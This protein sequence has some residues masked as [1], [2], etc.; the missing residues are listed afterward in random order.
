MLA[1]SDS[2]TETLTVRELQV[3]ALAARG[4][5]DKQIAKVLGISEETVGHRWRHLLHHLCAVN[6]AHAV[7]VALSQGYCLETTRMCH[8]T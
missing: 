3:L 7:F 8:R 4:L 2:D 5:H 6:R 1:M